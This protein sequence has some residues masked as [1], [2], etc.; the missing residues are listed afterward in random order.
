MNTLEFAMKVLFRPSDHFRGD[1]EEDYYKN[2]EGTHDAIYYC[3]I[4]AEKNAMIKQFVEYEIEE[5][6]SILL[7]FCTFSFQFSV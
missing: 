6:R 3:L 2:I 7:Y 5:Y 1:D 4:A